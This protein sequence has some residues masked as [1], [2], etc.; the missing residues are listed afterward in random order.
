MTGSHRLTSGLEALGSS[1]LA[2]TA[3]ALSAAWLS[4]LLAAAAALLGLG[5]TAPLLV[6]ALSLVMAFAACAGGSFAC[7]AASRLASRAPLRG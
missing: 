6:T 3:I 4:L 7:L 1:L 5:G 2:A